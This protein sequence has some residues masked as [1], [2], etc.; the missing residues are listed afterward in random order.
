MVPTGSEY[1]IIPLFTIQYD[2]DQAR[3]WTTRGS[4]PGW[5]KI[6]SNVQTSSGAHPASFNGYVRDLSPRIKHEG[7]KA[8]HRK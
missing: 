4:L 1:T 2:S 8:H 3:G 5:G 6:L 7:H